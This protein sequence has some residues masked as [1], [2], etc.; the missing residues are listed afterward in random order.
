MRCIAVVSR[1]IKARG[2]SVLRGRR[3]RDASPEPAPPVIRFL[4]QSSQPMGEDKMTRNEIISVLGPV[5][6]A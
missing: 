2:Q 3:L 4:G 6:E 5:D 1:E